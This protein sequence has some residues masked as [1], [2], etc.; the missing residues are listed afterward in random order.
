MSAAARLSPLPRAFFRR[1]PE[2]VAPDLLGQLVLRDIGGGR[3]LAAR[4]VEVE[5]YLGQSDPAAHAFRGP[6]PRNATLFGPPGHAYVYTSYGL[7]QCL[8]VS[9]QPAG[10]AGG[11]LIRALEP[12]RAA[13]AAE[14]WLAAHAPGAAPARRLSGPGRLCRTLAITRQFDG[15]DLTTTGDLW[16]ATGPPPRIIAVTCRVGIRRAVERPLRFYDLDS[17]AVSGPRGPRV[18]LLTGGRGRWRIAPGPR[19]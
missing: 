6:T 11:V 15:A 17:R 2:R 5:A 9:T 14:R 16:L 10:Q 19:A 12:E 1:P 18:A 8:N 4:I 13:P 7:H 3:R